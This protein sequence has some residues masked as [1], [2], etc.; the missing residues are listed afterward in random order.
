MSM[1]RYQSYLSIKKS[2]LIILLLLLSVFIDVLNGFLVSRFSLH[3]P[4]SQLYKSV[5]LLISIAMFTVV[6][7]KD[8]YVVYLL[9]CLIFMLLNTVTINFNHLA[10]NTTY[11]PDILYTL[12]KLTVVIVFFGAMVVLD[13]VNFKESQILNM[14]LAIYYLIFMSLILSIF[15]FGENQYGENSEGLAY[16]YK[17]FFFAGNEL[18]S[19]YCVSYGFVLYQSLVSKDGFLRLLL[20]VSTGA[21]ISVLLATKTAMLSFIIITLLLPFLLS[22]KS[23]NL[24]LSYRNKVRKKLRLLSISIVPLFFLCIYFLSSRIELLVERFTF[25]FN[26]QGGT[27]TGLLLSGRHHRYDNLSNILDNM[28]ILDVLFGLGRESYVNFTYGVSRRYSAEMDLLDSFF[29]HGVIGTIL[30]YSFWIYIVFRTFMLYKKN[31]SS[32]VIVQLIVSLLLF[33]NSFIAGHIMAASMVMVF[34]GFSTA[35]ILKLDNNSIR[36]QL[37]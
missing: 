21:I 2:N 14:Y 16:G 5:I 1:R 8:K 10:F 3:T 28:N 11:I 26:Q 4:I 19:L 35:F 12:K 24:V 32:I 20:L 30:I 23:N 13:R 17:G 6:K 29:A 22:K 36:K 31:S 7:Y 27:V 15:G 37:I 33:A 25:L 9:L 34:Y 18:T